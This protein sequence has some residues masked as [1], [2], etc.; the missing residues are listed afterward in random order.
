MKNIIMALAMLNLVAVAPAFAQKKKTTKAAPAAAA[1]A[2]EQPVYSY[3]GGSSGSGSGPE[4]SVQGMLG[5]V[6]SAFLIGP[7]VNAEW[8]MDL[9]GKP[10]YIGG[11][12]G[13]L[14]GDATIIPILLSGR[15]MFDSTGSMTPYAGASMGVSIATASG[16]GSAFTFLARGGVNFGAEKNLFAE[17]PLGAMGGGFAILPTF[18]YRF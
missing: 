6:S 13:V 18:G 4:F 5:S 3:S 2:Q 9:D 15:L 12:T 10:L 16:G 14:F 7:M 11:Q 8:K 17:L 1:P